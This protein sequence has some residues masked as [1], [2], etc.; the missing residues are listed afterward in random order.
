MLEGRYPP[1]PCPRCETWGEVFTVP[2]G[3]PIWS[4]RSKRASLVVESARLMR[5][6]SPSLPPWSVKIS[7]PAASSRPLTCEPPGHLGARPEAEFAQ[8]MLDV[9]FNR[10]LGNHQPLRNVVMAQPVRD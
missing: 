9:H 7:G 4:T 3:L 5:Q 2:L 8:E 6:T 1:H 10:A